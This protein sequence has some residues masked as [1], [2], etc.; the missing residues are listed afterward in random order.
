[1]N[2]DIILDMIDPPPINEFVELQNTMITDASS[3]GLVVRKKRATNAIKPPKN[4]KLTCD[5]YH[6]NP[7]DLTKYKIPELKALAKLYK[8][9]ITGNKTTLIRRIQNYFQFS[10][11]VIVIQKNLRRFFVKRS[12]QLRG[13]AKHD[14]SICTNPTD[15]YTLEPLDEIPHQE[16]FSYTEIGA[17]GQYT[18]GF[19]IQSLMQLLRR[20]GRAIVNPYNREKIPE[21][22]IGDFIRLYLYTIILFPEHV[23]EEERYPNSRNQFLQPAN[24]FAIAH[25]AYYGF[26]SRIR[27]R[28]LEVDPTV[29][30][31]TVPYATVRL[32]S[33]PSTLGSSGPSLVSDRRSLEGTEG[34]EDTVG[35]LAATL[36]DN[37]RREDTT[38]I[39]NN[40][41]ISSTAVPLPQDRLYTSLEDTRSRLR[42]IRSKSM[43]V[44]I[45]ELFME[46][47]QL[48]NYTQVSW[49]TN[50]TRREL[51]N[52]YVRLHNVWR[53]RSRMP[54][55]VRQRICPLGDPFPNTILLG[56][57]Y[58]QIPAD[59]LMSEVVSTMENLSYTAVDIEDRKL[60]VIYALIA[61]TYVSLPARENLIWLYESM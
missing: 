27:R 56:M 24:V 5:E 8:L 7:T 10:I 61:L 4:T 29:P 46:I 41:I 19:N 14:R 52:Y 33:R 34:T 12:F 30:D 55:S 15:F 53:H 2:E 54:F 45:Q 26:P 60:G 23:S 9:H 42:E 22:A 18:Y 47:D 25:G 44:R 31:A 38:P 43:S 48:G 39:L 16:F 57:R 50:L 28:L 49:F 1:M 20:K 59:Q 21:K 37:I 32:S 11:S 3:T 51:Y 40:R 58:D 17:N 6:K 35:S 13:P 36:L